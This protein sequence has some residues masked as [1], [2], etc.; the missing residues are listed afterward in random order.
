MPDELPPMADPS[1]L[2]DTDEIRPIKPRPAPPASST[3]AP[4]SEAG[5]ELEAGALPEAS[6]PIPPPIPSRTSR[7]GRPKPSVAFDVPDPNFDEDDSTSEEAPRKRARAS[8]GDTSEFET[9]AV[10]VDPVWNRAAEWGPDLVKVG[11]A[12]FS[13]LFLAW[14]TFNWFFV[15]IFVLLVGGAITA[16]L[17]YPILITFERPVRIT[18]E[19]AV[20]D[21]FAAASHHF[22]HY[23]RMWLLLSTAGREAGGFESFEQFRDHWKALIEGWRG[24]EHARKFTPL[25]F[26]LRDFRADKSTGTMTSKAQYHVRVGYRDKPDLGEI[27]TFKMAHGLVKGPDRMWYLNR[28]VPSE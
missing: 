22:P 26:A 15:C 28:G 17:S 7:S 4:P 24:P 16:V 20:T 1:S 9:E 2:F 19:Q 23:R 13:T 18:P 14:L 21:F 25:D 6:E 11:I 8:T 27:A 10:L 12:G 3:P 5:Y